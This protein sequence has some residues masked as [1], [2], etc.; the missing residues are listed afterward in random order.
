MI[1][2]VAAFF[3]AGT[4]SAAEVA[5]EV[6]VT[7][8]DDAVAT[9]EVTLDFTSGEGIA[10]G[11]ITLDEDGIDGYSLGTEV[12]GVSL[13]YGEQDDI[14]L[15][16]GLNVVGGSTLADPASAETSLIMGVGD[17]EVLVGFGDDLTDV[18][19]VQMGYSLGIVSASVD[20]NLDSEDFTVVGSGEYTVAGIDGGLTVSYADSFAY[21]ASTGLYGISVYVNGDEDDLLENV[22]AGYET[23]VGGVTVFGEA[24]YNLDT[25]EVTPAVGVSFKF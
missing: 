22:G 6:E 16:G 15:G 19:N 9:T 23:D 17:A 12:V 10:T 24:E 5:G 13:S 20:Y 21:E 18:D 3:M 11:S 8:D 25:E 14:M 4:V 7:V 1:A 2:A